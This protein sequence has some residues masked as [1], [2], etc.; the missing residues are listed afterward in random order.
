MVVWDPHHHYL[1]GGLGEGVTTIFMVVWD[2][3]HN[4]LCGGLRPNVF[5]LGGC[6]FG[7]QTTTIL[8]NGF[9]A[10]PQLFCVVVWDAH[11]HNCLWWFWAIPQHLLWLFGA[12]PLLFCV[13]VSD[14]NHFYFVCARG[15]LEPRPPIFCMGFVIQTIGYL[16]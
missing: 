9:V 4:I 14:P 8:C 3:N 2:P 10:K 16:L 12:Q 1:C 13:V 11:H 5:F 7:T 15:A 6:C